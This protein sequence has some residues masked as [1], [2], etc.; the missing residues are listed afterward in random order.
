MS[1][2]FS[3][4]AAQNSQYGAKE[5]KQQIISST[6]TGL[7]VSLLVMFAF[8]GI[9][10][11]NEIILNDNT[12]TTGLDIGPIVLTNINTPKVPENIPIQIQ[13]SSSLQQM[14][15][16]QTIASTN[17]VPVSNDLLT[18]DFADLK[19]MGQ[20]SAS[21]GIA[22]KIELDKVDLDKPR[23]VKMNG[24]V[25]T[26][27]DPNDT[28]IVVEKEAV[29]DYEGLQKTIVY[30]AI[31]L[32]TGMEGSVVVQVLIGADGRPTQTRVLSSTNVAFNKEAIRAVMEFTGYKPAIQNQAPVAYWLAIPINFKL[33]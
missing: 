27:G 14:I 3:F 5:L 12:C 17:I 15:G 29:V 21:K 25:E 2:L 31:P 30:P 8:F 6:R 32:K 13:Q 7:F 26:V 4:L 23:D 19:D 28:F 24:V 1:A 18:N 33:K 16:T 22:D 20:V 11:L 10:K 9:Y